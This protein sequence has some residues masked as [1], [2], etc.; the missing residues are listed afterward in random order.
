M[1]LCNVEITALS[2]VAT[3]RPPGQGAGWSPGC[4]GPWCIVADVFPWVLRRSLR[5]HLL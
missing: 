3:D 1:V 5:D 4:G 2:D